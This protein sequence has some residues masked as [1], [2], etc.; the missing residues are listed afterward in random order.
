MNRHLFFAR[1]FSLAAVTAISLGLGMPAASPA[2]QESGQQ[3]KILRYR[4]QTG[5][6]AHIYTWKREAQGENVL[7]TVEEPDATFTNLCTPDGATLSWT[8]AAP[9][10]T[11]LRAERKA[12]KLHIQGILQGK[13]VD[14]QLPLG[15]KPWFQ[16]LS[17]ALSRMVALERAKTEFWFL[18]S[19]KLELLAMRAE[20]AGKEQVEA[21]GKAVA[22]RRVRI[23]LDSLMAA[24]WEASYWF[25][26]ADQAFLRYQGVNGPP[27]TDE[28][29]IDLQPQ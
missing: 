6:A 4:E 2:K 5:K 29:V 22:A 19:D 28:T 1:A 15:N 12:D 26:D 9:P 7:L 10:N 3:T 14:K 11:R 21:D 24:F 16:S 8:M 18:R 17:F 23:K 25:R 27:G 13:A 20:L